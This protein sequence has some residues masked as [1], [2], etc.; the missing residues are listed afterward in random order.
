M[1]ACLIGHTPEIMMSLSQRL[2]VLA[3]P[4]TLL[5]TG[6]AGDHSTRNTVFWQDF[7]CLLRLQSVPMFFNP[8]TQRLA[9]AVCMTKLPV[10]MHPRKAAAKPVMDQ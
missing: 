5:I 4:I 1:L 10:Y 8:D 3:D 9:H 7:L 6:I 2:C